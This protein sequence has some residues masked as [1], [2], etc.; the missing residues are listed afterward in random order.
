MNNFDTVF[1]PPTKNQ[2]TEMKNKLHLNQL[3]SEPKRANQPSA[4]STNLELIRRGVWKIG[5]HDRAVPSPNGDRSAYY[6]ADT[7]K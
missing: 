7:T 2:L 4:I 6:F 1:S 5:F 3:N